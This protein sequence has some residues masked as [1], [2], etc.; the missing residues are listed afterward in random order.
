MNAEQLTRESRAMAEKTTSEAESRAQQ[1]DTEASERRSVLFS[2]LEREQA[3]LT[4]KITALR[5]FEATYRDNLRGYLSKHLGALDEDIPEP[6]GVPGLAA[7]RESDTPRL[8]ALAQG[9]DN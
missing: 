6:A 5:G 7:A 8:D 9:S 4:A 1:V 3:E 2:D